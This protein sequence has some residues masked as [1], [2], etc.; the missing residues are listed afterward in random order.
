[1]RGECAEFSA[2]FLRSYDPST[3]SVLLAN[4][5]KLTPAMQQYWD[6]KK[7][8]HDVRCVSTSSPCTP[9]SPAPP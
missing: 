5:E 1:M 2:S 4:G 3:L 9:P 8:H 7:N 6:I